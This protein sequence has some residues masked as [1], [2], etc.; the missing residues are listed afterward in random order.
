MQ[1]VQVQGP[2]G[3]QEPAVLSLGED[4]SVVV[5]P[6]EV[7]EQLLPEPEP[8]VVLPVPVRSARDR[9]PPIWHGDYDLSYSYA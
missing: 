8:D 9:H 4:I 3:D 7:Q 5:L 2:D 6:T 1:E